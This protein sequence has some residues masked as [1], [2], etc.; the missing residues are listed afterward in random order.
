MKETL[1]DGN[2]VGLYTWVKLHTHAKSGEHRD[3]D[4]GRNSA[5]NRQ[6]DKR[7]SNLN[8]ITTQLKDLKDNYITVEL[9][10]M[11]KMS[12]FQIASIQY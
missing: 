1:H 7:F 5:T 6:T 3:I 11:K 2:T 10:L 4:L 12:S 8:R 9:S